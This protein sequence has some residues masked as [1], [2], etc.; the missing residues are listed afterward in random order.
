MRDFN[1]TRA[2][3]AAGYSKKSAHVVGWE[4]L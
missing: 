1:A 3:K 2:V 4:T